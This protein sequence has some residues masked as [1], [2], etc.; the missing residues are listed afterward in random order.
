[1]S[2]LWALFL[3]TI[4]FC[5]FLQRSAFVCLVVNAVSFSD[6]IHSIIKPMCVSLHFNSFYILYIHFVR[7]VLYISND[8]YDDNDTN[9]LHQF[10]EEINT[11]IRNLHD[12]DI[13]CLFFV[14]QRRCVK[15]LEKVFTAIWTILCHWNTLNGQEKWLTQ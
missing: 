4:I 12:G 5:S 8:C 13:F 11:Y 7:F 10:S 2:L 9:A 3:S 6:G 15:W 1:M 14:L